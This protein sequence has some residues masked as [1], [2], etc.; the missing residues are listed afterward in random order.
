MREM[1]KAPCTFL[2]VVNDEEPTHPDFWLG[3]REPER[4]VLHVE[5]APADPATRA[6][7]KQ[8]LLDQAVTEQGNLQ[9][10][11]YAAVSADAAAGQAR[12]E[13]A[14]DRAMLRTPADVMRLALAEYG[15]TAQHGEDVGNSWLEV[16]GP[17]GSYAVIYVDTSAAEGWDLPDTC[18]DMP[19][20]E[21]GGSEWFV[22]AVGRDHAERLA[23]STPIETGVPACVEYIADWLTAP[24]EPGQAA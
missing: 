13:F 7:R 23:L 15:I 9:V 17:G 1:T 12:A 10:L 24:E 21:L 19:L 11:E 4:D 22:L 14:A 5:A 20:A 8:E 3:L 18:V 16:D 6:E 2:L